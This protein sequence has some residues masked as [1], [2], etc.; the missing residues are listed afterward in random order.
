[1][2]EQL[3]KEEI[4]YLIREIEGN[5]SS[6]QR[7]L[8]EKVGISLGKTNYLIKA[9]IS[10]G[11]VKYKSF[12]E[13]PGKIQKI[14]YSLT[15]KG[16]QERARLIQLYLKIKEEEYKKIKHEWEELSGRAISGEDK[17]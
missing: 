3:P 16:L 12:S 8:S 15:K 14:Q 5:S 13:N 4:L 10:K 7:A 17:E 9:L 2:N 11:M 1:M 6:T